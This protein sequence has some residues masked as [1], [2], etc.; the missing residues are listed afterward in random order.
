MSPASAQSVELKKE[1]D[2]IV[3]QRP[4]VPIVPV[5][6]CDCNRSDFGPTIPHLQHIDFRNS[7]ER[8]RMRLLA[9][10]F[11]E[12]CQRLQNAHAS[13]RDERC[14]AVELA[15][16]CERL[17]EEIDQLDE[18]LGRANAQLHSLATFDGKVWERPAALPFPTFRP[19]TDRKCR[20]IAVTNLK[21]GV[22]KTTLTA[23]LGAPLWT[24]GKQVLLIDLDYQGTLTAICLQAKE[25]GD[26][27]R[28]GHL[29]KLINSERYLT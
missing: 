19:R 9:F 2:R 24:T 22:G 27:S 26:V 28:Q 1:I 7:R 8:A 6:L 3:E 20:V 11:A 21:G 16:E 10:F 15:Q 14:K 23:N 4:G 5:L 13:A 18:Q 12:L 29:I 25:V 17:R